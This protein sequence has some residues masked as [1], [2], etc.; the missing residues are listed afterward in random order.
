M[1]FVTVL[2]FNVL[3]LNVK[4]MLIFI[5]GISH[6]YVPIKDSACHMGKE[7]FTTHL[8]PR[9]REDLLNS[10]SHCASVTVSEFT[11]SMHL[12]SCWNIP[13]P[14]C[15]GTDSSLS[16]HRSDLISLKFKIFNLDRF[17]FPLS[18]FWNRHAMCLDAALICFSNAMREINWKQWIMHL[19]FL[20]DQSCT[21]IL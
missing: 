8:E 3:T 5:E 18:R 1:R 20:F 9:R 14:S 15:C 21:S 11:D 2:H 10:C 19:I 12:I 13:A 7:C 17:F 4:W 16:I 6:F